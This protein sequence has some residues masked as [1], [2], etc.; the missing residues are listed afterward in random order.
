MLA[1]SYL[2]LWL[3]YG[4]DDCFARW[5]VVLALGQQ[6]W[7]SFNRGNQSSLLCFKM[8]ARHRAQPLGQ[9]LWS[10]RARTLWASISCRGRVAA[11]G[12]LVCTDGAT[13]C[14]SLAL[15]GPGWPRSVSRCAV[16]WAEPRL[17]LPSLS[18][19]GVHP[20]LLFTNHV[21]PLAYATAAMSC[22]WA[23]S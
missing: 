20:T 21:V 18:R 19:R 16:H 17:W 5:L 3:L 11:V 9:S 2:P 10:P 23:R 8:N 4:H 12:Q 6:N 1:S 22:S 7:L 14:L 13:Q 15:A